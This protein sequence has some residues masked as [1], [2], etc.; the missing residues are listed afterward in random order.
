MVVQDALGN[1]DELEHAPLLVIPHELGKL[2]LE[3]LVEAL[4]LIL[5]AHQVEHLVA[6]ILTLVVLYHLLEAKGILCHLL[7]GQRNNTLEVVFVDRLENFK[8]LYF[9]KL[10]HLV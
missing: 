6:Q 7:L 2:N 5:I 8:Q 10:W 9:H 4:Y 1:V 3:V